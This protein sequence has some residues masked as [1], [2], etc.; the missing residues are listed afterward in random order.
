MDISTKSVLVEAH[1]LVRLVERAYLDLQRAYQVISEELR[2][3]STK[4]LTLQ[5]AVKAVNDTAGPDGLVPT[6]LVF[7]AYPRMTK[8]D[9]PALSITAR[10]T[11]VR[12]AMA[13]ITKL[14][15]RKSVNDALHHRNG[16]DTAPLHDL[17]LNSEVLV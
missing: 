16:P 14:R 2:T 13:K 11:A 1:W 9:P 17:P 8:L 15:A 5:M 3:T 4:E 6:L 12:K 10:A 7:G